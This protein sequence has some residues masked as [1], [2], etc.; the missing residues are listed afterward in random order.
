MLSERLIGFA[1]NARASLRLKAGA[2]LKIQGDEVVPGVLARIAHCVHPVHAANVWSFL[3]NGACLG[4][5]QEVSAGSIATIQKA[6]FVG[7]MNP[8]ATQAASGAGE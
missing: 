5:R 8:L 4:V 6:R 7:E 3:V 2:G 1:S